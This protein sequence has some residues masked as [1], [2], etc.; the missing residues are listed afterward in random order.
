MGSLF[1]SCFLRGGSKGAIKK[2]NERS[3]NIDNGMQ[4]DRIPLGASSTKSRDYTSPAI[5][6]LR[7]DNNCVALSA[8]G[9]MAGELVALL[10]FAPRPKREATSA[11]VREDSPRSNSNSTLYG[12]EDMSIQVG[13]ERASAEFE[14]LHVSGDLQLALRLPDNASSSTAQYLDLLLDAISEG[15]ELLEIFLQR[16]GQALLLGQQQRSSKY[17]VT[18]P[19]PLQGMQLQLE[20]CS[21]RTAGAGAAVPALMVRHSW[22]VAA[23]SSPAW[24]QP[25]ASAAGDTGTRG[26]NQLVVVAPGNQILEEVPALLTMCTPEGRVLFQVRVNSVICVLSLGVG[27]CFCVLQNNLPCCPCLS[28]SM[29]LF[30][31]QNGLSLAFYGDLNLA[32]AL[33]AT[34]PDGFL[35]R[36]LSLDSSDL[37]GELLGTVAEGREWRKMAKIPVVCSV[38]GTPVEGSVVADGEAA[39]DD[40]DGPGVQDSLLLGLAGTSPSRHGSG[41]CNDEEWAWSRSRS[42]NAGH[43]GPSLADLIAASGG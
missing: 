40:D 4:W 3:A 33:P 1:L 30:V 6:H 14:I 43:R 38:Q 29:P 37:L 21:W 23:P 12:P 22:A 17:V 24:P 20:Q 8:G 13:T 35:A 18:S 32:D 41:Q 10:A 11:T 34:S 15:D 9:I 25:A 7:N 19:G 26:G 39:S 36:L 42:R 16:A 27:R 2:D 5:G 28:Y 31:L